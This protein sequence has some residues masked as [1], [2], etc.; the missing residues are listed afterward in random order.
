VDSPFV[1]EDSPFVVKD[2]PFA[3]EDIALAYPFVIA[4]DNQLATSATA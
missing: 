1:V 4:V 2:D 3:I